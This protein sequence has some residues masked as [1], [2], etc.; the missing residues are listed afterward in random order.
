[1]ATVANIG[2]GTG[3]Y[4]PAHTIVAVEPSRVMIAQRPP[5][6][7]PA[8]LA[9]AEQ[10]PIRSNAVDA[11]LAVLTVHHWNDLAQG[12]EEMRRI[13]RRRLV[14]FTWDQTLFRQFWLIRDYLPAAAQTDADLAVPIA[15]LASLL[16]DPR[17]IPVPV[18]HDCLDGFGGAY[19][20]RPHAYL[21]SAV[22]SG[23]S[24][25]ALTPKSELEQ[26]LSQLQADLDSGEW[27]RRYRDLLDVEELDLG[28]RLLVAGFD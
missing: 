12:I 26:G 24:L 17:I 16:G 6:C 14:V 18:P 27:A 3:S 4:E 13:A 20:R 11:A 7:A 19:W 9:V 25:F 8:V 21:D 1:M 22:Q 15:K 28:Y 23:M 10:L 2:A 5:G